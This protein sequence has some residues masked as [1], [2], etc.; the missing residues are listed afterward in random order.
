[1]CLCQYLLYCKSVLCKTGQSQPKLLP[2][3]SLLHILLILLFSF[4]LHLS[5]LFS[6]IPPSFN[7][8]HCASFVLPTHRGTTMLQP[9]LLARTQLKLNF[10][11]PLFLPP[12]F[13]FPLLLALL[14]FCSS[15]PPFFLFS[16]LSLLFLLLCASLLSFVPRSGATVLQR[17]LTPCYK[18]SL[19]L[20][21]TSCTAARAEPTC[22]HCT[23][24]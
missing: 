14:L 9:F 1:M 23:L 6:P 10:F 24:G 18:V 8:P 3:V 22:H 2:L 13:F 5:L 12:S 20:A 17:F 21:G 19:C 15:Y 11:L 16:S 4:P 7:L